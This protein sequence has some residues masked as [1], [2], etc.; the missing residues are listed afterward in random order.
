MEQTK[1]TFKELG[2]FEKPHA[3]ESFSRGNVFKSS[4]VAINPK[5]DTSETCTNKE[6]EI[7]IHRTGENIDSIEFRCLCGKSIE[8]K[9]EYDGD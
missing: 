4:A 3:K 7:I 1:D 6:P 9:L 2:S 5:K 8:V